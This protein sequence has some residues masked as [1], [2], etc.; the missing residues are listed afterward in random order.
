MT[1][2]VLIDVQ[3]GF[4]D[5]YWGRRNNPRFEV[6]IARLLERWRA[7]QLPVIHVQ[8]HSTEPQSPLR[9]DRPGVEFMACAR[10]VPGETIFAKKVNSAFIHTG[11]ESYLR[12]RGITSL[13]MAGLTTDHCVSTSARMGANLG[14]AITIPADAVATFDRRT[15]DGMFIPAETV[16]EVALASLHG[17]FA[18]V[19]SSA[20]LLE[21]KNNTL[22]TQA[23][24]LSH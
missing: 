14:F 19:T 5:P 1:A 20:E 10:P 3:E 16:H 2:L 13:V 22:E 4:H 11:L 6:V 24:L 17:E 9:P 15:Y 12:A 18:V 7:A 21:N 23:I 8:H